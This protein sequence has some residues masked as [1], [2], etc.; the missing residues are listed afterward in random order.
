[1]ED[2]SN[3]SSHDVTSD[4]NFTNDELEHELLDDIALQDFALVMN[5]LSVKSQRARLA[6]ALMLWIMVDGEDTRR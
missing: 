4:D 1:M 5:G 3:A 6:L 2:S